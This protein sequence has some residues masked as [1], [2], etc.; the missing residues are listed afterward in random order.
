VADCKVAIR[1]TKSEFAIIK[2]A[3]EITNMNRASFCRGFI[4]NA[5]E[6]IL[7]RS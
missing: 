6:G 4:L 7:A 3:S 2:K 5:A 1:L